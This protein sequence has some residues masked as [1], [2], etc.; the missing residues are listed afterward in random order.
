[1]KGEGEGT[2]LPRPSPPHA[3]ASLIPP[4]FCRE[5]TAGLEYQLRL[6]LAA[7]NRKKIP[8]SCFHSSAV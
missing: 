8:E 5:G 7:K 1:M 3:S 4:A 2:F 6:S